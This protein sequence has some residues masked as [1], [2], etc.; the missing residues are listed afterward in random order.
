MGAMCSNLLHTR[1][2]GSHYH[3]TGTYKYCVS[4]VNTFVECCNPECVQ[5]AI[6]DNSQMYII[7]QCEHNC[8]CH[9]YTQ[10]G[11]KYFKLI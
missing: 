3:Y 2:E 6:I 5:C 9:L 1:K 4:N 11:V 10:D 7:E 8:R